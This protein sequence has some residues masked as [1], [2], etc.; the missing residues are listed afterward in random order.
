[1]MS[2]YDYYGGYYPPQGY[3]G[4]TGTS[5][6][7]SVR[8]LYLFPFYCLAYILET[9]PKLKIDFVPFNIS[10]LDSYLIIA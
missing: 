2:G 6:S 1:M 5:N 3:G 10:L 8:T 7:S 4:F 9:A